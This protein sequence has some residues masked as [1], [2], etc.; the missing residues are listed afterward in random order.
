MSDSE[1]HQEHNGVSHEQ[2]ENHSVNNNQNNKKKVNKAVKSTVEAPSI[3]VSAIRSIF[4]FRKTSL[5][6]FVVL[7][8][9]LVFIAVYLAKLNAL[10]LPSKEPEILSSSW[11]D[12]QE[13]SKHPH[14]YVSH[15]N[16]ELHDYLVERVKKLSG[17][18]KY[19]EYSDDYKTSLS[20]FYIQ[21][22]TWDPSDNSGTLN[23]FE[24]S[25][26][27]AKVEGKDPSLPAILLSAHYDSVPTAYGSTDDGA[28]VAS[29][30]GIL[31][32][33]AT[34]K[35]QPLRTIIFNINNNEEF[36][37]YGAQ[38]FFDHPWSQNASYFVNLEGTGTGERAILFRST[39]YEIASH[40]KTARSPFGTSIFQQGFASRLVHSETDYKVYHEH[41]LRGI[42]IAFYKPR[43]LYHTKYDSIQQTSKNALWHMLSNA[44]D[45]TK[46]L[47]DSKTIS[48]DEETQA[49]FFD[50]LGLY[51]VVLPL[52]SLY[53]INIVLLTVI[54]ITLLG[55]AVIIQKR[56]IWD[57]GFSWVRIP[58][59]FA[60]SG[61][62]AK[63]VS[64]LI[65][66]VNPLVISR[67]Y[68][69]PLLTVSATFLFINYV[70]LT[71][72]QHIWPV[73]DFKLLITMEVFVILW[74][75]LVG[76]T[77]SE[78]PPS[79]Y[80][81]FYLIT[82][83]YSLYS[84]SV[85]LGLLGIALASPNREK[86]KV[87][88]YGSVSDEADE[89]N[90]EQTNDENAPLLSNS[91]PNS[92]SEDVEEHEGE[93][94]KGHPAH[95]SF[96]YDWS[97]QFLILVPITFLITYVSGDLILQGLNQ[98]SQESLKSTNFVY[99]LILLFGTLLVTPLLGFSYKLNAWFAILLIIA[100]VGG[101]AKSLFEDPFTADSPLKLRFV[102]DIN[103]NNASKP[104]VTVSGREGELEPILRDLPSVKQYN[105][106]ISCQSQGDGLQACS[107]EAE[108][109]YLFDGSSK[110]NDLD[111]YLKIDILKNGAEKNHS[112]FSPLTAEIS[113]KAKENRYCS[114]SFNST[115]FKS[116]EYGQSPI[117]IV[118]Y[119]HDQKT[120]TST[121]I[122]ESKV[123]SENGRSKDDKGNDV[124][125]W[126]PGIDGI[127][128]H[129]LDWDQPSYHI[130]LQWIPD[131]LKDGEEE[132]PSDSPKNRLGIQISCFWGE[133]ERESIIDGKG[134]RKIPA[135]DELL[136]YS[137]TTVSWTNRY[138]GLVKIDRYVEV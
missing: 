138:E 43:S 53:I 63:I 69:A 127:Q 19:I 18:K 70:V 87:A 125:K 111:S 25:N 106:K 23:Y 35:Q 50:I 15:A 113:I 59:S 108:R 78:K 6:L 57:V 129:K 75:S 93:I 68:T 123:K 48:D 51:F 61:I 10:S 80:T 16:D 56:E 109:P 132:E 98:T 58:I 62:G 74:A 134:V 119:F 42:D 81:G 27:L 97:L 33:Y 11:S 34:S 66:F 24:S 7:A 121:I 31:E 30:L 105:S 122:D 95:N 100:I 91:I 65:R 60:L 94:I 5:T 103:L 9:G 54:P 46:S 22:N 120:N 84:V 37:L 82:I 86:I 107:Y 99:Q 38:A 131:W 90:N 89:A 96:T 124:F 44:L 72:S 32:Y 4:G 88:T 26:V 21:R 12:L 112:P 29:L 76:A 17:L 71:V 116:Y 126:L 2:E 73:H 102:Q 1:S 64:D 47:A 133:Y 41:G 52:T 85:F 101:G 114:L 55:F 83:L 136:Q 115:T 128:L 49:V 79:I 92:D 36:G 67:D 110:S 135:F 118:R 28:G 8:Y 45:V 39:D 13:I 3:F 77:V 117:K 130:G 20:S 137:P 14:P 104:I 40:Y